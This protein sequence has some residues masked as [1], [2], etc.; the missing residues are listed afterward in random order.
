MHSS[1]WEEEECL[2]CGS[3]SLVFYLI[4]GPVSKGLVNKAGCEFSV[5]ALG[6]APPTAAMH[7]VMWS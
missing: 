5:K 2:Q 6:A 1:S 3:L 7:M 4:S